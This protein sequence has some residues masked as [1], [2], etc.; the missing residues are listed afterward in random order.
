MSNYLSVV[1]LSIISQIT[2][3]MPS[4]SISGIPINT[5]PSPGT[6]KNLHLTQLSLCLIFTEHLLS[7]LMFDELY[8][9]STIYL[10]FVAFNYAIVD[11]GSSILN[12]LNGIKFPSLLLYFYTF[13][14]FF[15]L[16][17]TVVNIADFMLWNVKDFLLI[18]LELLMLSTQLSTGTSFSL[19]ISYMHLGYCSAGLPCVCPL[20]L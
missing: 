6:T 19:S 20:E 9:L 17:L 11:L 15:G 1:L 8:V 2:L 18:Q 5:G 10:S 4:N 16:Y 13:M 7:C 12:I 14:F 3:I